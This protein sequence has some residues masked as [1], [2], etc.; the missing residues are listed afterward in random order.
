MQKEGVILQ[1]EEKDVLCKEEKEELTSNRSCCS[2]K[3]E[4]EKW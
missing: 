2:M 4:T 1:K 3:E